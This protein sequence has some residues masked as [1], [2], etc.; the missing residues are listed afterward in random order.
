MLKIP[1]DLYKNV[2]ILL[3]IK[4]YSTVYEHL[5]YLGRKTICQYLLNNALENETLI[6]TPED[7]DSLMQLIN[8]LIVDANDKPTDYEED[9]E[10]FMEEQ[11]LVSRLI[12]LMRSNNL[13]EQ[14]IVSLNLSLAS[15]FK[16]YASN[17]ASINFYCNISINTSFHYPSVDLKNFY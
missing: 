6:S 11:T 17:F 8:P 7:V 14:F 15:C 13:D 2:L 3:K 5:D 12:H 1:I 4:H 10:D 16:V 9:S